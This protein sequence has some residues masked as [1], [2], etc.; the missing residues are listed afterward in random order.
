MGLTKW[1]DFLLR[2]GVKL[3]IIVEELDSY[4]DQNVIEFRKATCNSCVYR[5]KLKNKCQICKCDLSLKWTTKKNRN[6]KTGRV[7]ITHCP[8]GFWNDLQIAKIYNKKNNLNYD[9]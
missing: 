3:V 9:L 1:G 6:K 8:Y 4:E 7:E 2:E 5:D